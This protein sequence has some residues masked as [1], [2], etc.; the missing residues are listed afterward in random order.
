MTTPRAALPIAAAMLGWLLIA[1]L[2]PSS[3]GWEGTGLWLLRL[4]LV[5][6]GLALA[7]AA[8]WWTM[9]KRGGAAA[10]PEIDAAIEEANRK[11]AAL[12]LGPVAAVPNVFLLGHSNAAKTT[13]VVRGVPDAQLLSGV[14]KQAGDVV[15]TKGLNVWFANGVVWFDPGPGAMASAAR[16][17]WMERVAAG[18]RQR[19]LSGGL[20]G[21]LNGTPPPMRS[22]VVLIET[23]AFLAQN[24]GEALMQRARALRQALESLVRAV[25]LRVPVYVLF[26]KMDEIPGFPEFAA[27]LNDAEVREALGSLLPLEREFNAEH[28]ANLLQG[29]FSRIAERLSD[30]R[31]EVLPRET[32][33]AK[34]REI[35]EFPRAFG[36]M[37]HMLLTFLGELAP[38]SAGAA[39]FLRGFYFT[40]VRAVQSR[41]SAAPG[42]IP[43]WVFLPRFFSDVVLDDRA[44]Q[45][46]SARESG[47]AAWKNWAFASA[48]V[49]ALLFAA[50][51][52]ISFRNNHRV[53]SMLADGA[54]AAIR[55]QGQGPVET[56]K[57]LEEMRVPLERMERFR[58]VR[59]PWIW[60][61]GLFTGTRAFEPAEGAYL[62]LLRKALLNDA[63][64]NLRKVLAN[65]QAHEENPQPVYEALKA[66]LITTSHPEKS[67]DA[68]LTPVLLDH[69]SNAVL[70]DTDRATLA[71][72]QYSFYAEL[73]HHQ[74]PQKTGPADAVI[75]SARKFLRQNTSIEPA[76]QRL[77]ARV[78]AEIPQFV[79]NEQY[80]KSANLV[81]NSYAVPGAFTRGGWDRMHTLIQDA[82]AFREE[83]WVLGAEGQGR[84][85]PAKMQA[86]VE[87]RY[88]ADFV[89]TW[90]EYLK[91]TRVV[92]YA[93]VQD[94]AMK[95]FALSENSSP[96]TA[97][98]CEASE[99][100]SVEQQAVAGLFSP[101]QQVTP[102]GC[103][104]GSL[105][106]SKDYLNALVTLAGAMKTLAAQP[107][108]EQLRLN[109]LVNAGTAEAT[110][111]QLARAFP[112]DPEGGIDQTTQSLLELPVAYVRG[113][114]E[115]VTK[116]QAEAQARTL[117]GQFAALVAK[118]P[119]KAGSAVAASKEEVTAFFDPG[120]GVL[121]RFYL[122]VGQKI[123]TRQGNWFVPKPGANPAASKA[124]ADFY[125]KAASASAGFFADGAENLTLGF[126]LHVLPESDLDSVELTIGR[127]TAQYSGQTGGQQKFSWS[128]GGA[129]RVLLKARF[130]GV[131]QAVEF[132]NPESV[133][134]P[135]GL[136]QGAEGW[137]K[138]GGVFAFDRTAKDGMHKLHLALEPSGSGELFQ[139][140]YFG[141]GCPAQATW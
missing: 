120:N 106:L 81:M 15:P 4:T 116:E 10:S 114:I 36:K 63:Q 70:A 87:S 28:E 56:L 119:F 67:T 131:A 26:T 11:L 103:R 14:A 101:P 3:F 39:P 132:P 104:A 18:E 7:G 12:R 96:L 20:K 44:A 112:L 85:D 48:A 43:Q 86:E 74:D 102:P 139:P 90:R 59:R 6:L 1:W 45:R 92:A 22:A 129:Q 32:D 42:R 60:G 138:A 80:P 108:A 21:L 30:Q 136:F 64:E 9:G 134:S 88:R 137:R 38:P 72:K 140:G 89:R 33:G 130:N 95:L 50:L 84:T 34:L 23:G 27:H 117:C 47:R 82:D 76:Y 133:W 124:F 69:S 83:E 46:V 79:F 110:V 141:F 62:S 125:S 35:Y 98:L 24:A 54:Y 128:P 29:E 68:F 71:A 66:Y 19:A 99:N 61:L 75:Q 16:A 97:V 107:G 91:A 37:R 123:L 109:A 105:G 17:Y 93:N 40:G 121:W 73:L 115:P 78:N 13:V 122:D 51:W 100:T 135:F 126:T 127:Q 8:L 41:D 53:V 52:M 111:R 55:G 31:L 25:G 57:S 118:A 113:L 5:F 94:A 58:H 65:P 77:V 2:V 49:V